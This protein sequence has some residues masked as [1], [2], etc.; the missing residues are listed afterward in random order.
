MKP[1]R[2]SLVLAAILLAAPF[3]GMLAIIPLSWASQRFPASQLLNVI[4]APVFVPV[5]YGLLALAHP[6]RY[7]VI[8]LAAIVAALATLGALIAAHRAQVW[9]R[10]TFYL[11]LATLAAVITFSLAA[12]AVCPRPP[13]GRRRRAAHGEPPDRLAGRGGAEPPSCHGATPRSV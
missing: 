3:W 1:T 9:R 12:A 10:P 7:V 4:S 13:G 6:I 2:T 5:F 8:S 11:C